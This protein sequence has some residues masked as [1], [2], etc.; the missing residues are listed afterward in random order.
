MEAMVVSEM[1]K[2]IL[3]ASTPYQIGG[4]E[5]NRPQQHLFTV[6]SMMSLYQK[7][8]KMLWINVYDLSAFFDRESLRDVMN[9]LHEV[10][11]HPK[12]YRTFYL[13]NK[14]TSIQVKTGTGM[15]ESADVGEIIGQ[16]SGG[17]ALASQVNLDKGMDDMFCGSSDEMMYGSVR[18]QPI[19]FQDDI[20]RLGDTLASV[21]AG[22]EKI[23]HVMQIRL[24]T[25]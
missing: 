9:T 25:S 24:D 15:S 2:P 10:K 13:L 4:Q 23:N 8:G 6:R 7:L 3:M 18:I 21:K 22:N 16:G 5:G 11:V 20:L 1:K 12:A 19:I 14:N 17:A